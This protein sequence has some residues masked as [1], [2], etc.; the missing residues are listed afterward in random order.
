[1]HG[2]FIH[3]I[4]IVNF[5]WI[6]ID[7]FCEFLV[8]IHDIFTMNI[9]WMNFS[10]IK[11]SSCI[12]VKWDV[13]EFL[14]NVHPKWYGAFRPLKYSMNIP[15]CILIFSEYSMNISELFVTYFKYSS[16]I[17]RIFTTFWVGQFLWHMCYI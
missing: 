11:Y 7:I 6:F 10:F 3:Q 15:R 8:N 16:N 2:V 5:S 14:M 9:W 4:F 12:F 17:W 1:M 13:S